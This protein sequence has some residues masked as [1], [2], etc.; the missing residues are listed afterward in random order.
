MGS[1][2][3]Y[4][5][6]VGA[7]IIGIMC[8]TGHGDIFMGGGDAQKRNKLYDM[9]KME[10]GCGIAMILAGIATAIDSQ[11]TTVSAKIAYIAAQVIIFGVL[12]YYMQVKCKKK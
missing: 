11:T 7:I 9:K 6:A 12:I 5:L 8:L 2:I 3:D 10:R 4:I 1:S